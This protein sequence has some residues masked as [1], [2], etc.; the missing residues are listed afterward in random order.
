MAQIDSQQVAVKDKGPVCVS[1]DTYQSI[2]RFAILHSLNQET[3]ALLRVAGK[4][5]QAVVDAEDELILVDDDLEIPCQV[6]HPAFFNKGKHQASAFLEEEKCRLQK[7][8][9][10]LNRK[11]AQND[12]EIKELRAVLYSKLGDAVQLEGNEEDD[13]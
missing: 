11:R 12:S 9:D 13:D 7:E 1:K 4:E 3:V 6:D 10:E 2:A 8:I 5:L